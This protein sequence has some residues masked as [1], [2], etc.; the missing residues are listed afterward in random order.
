[1]IFLY[2]TTTYSAVFERLVGAVSVAVDEDL[3]EN[4]WIFLSRASFFFLLLLGGG[5]SK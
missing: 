4:S 5:R 3:A 1:M 2:T